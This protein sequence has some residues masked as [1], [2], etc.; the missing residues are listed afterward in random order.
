[1]D[2][3][4]ALAEA[5]HGALYAPSGALLQELP[6]LLRAD[7]SLKDPGSVHSRL[8]SERRTSLYSQLI[9]VLVALVVLVPADDEQKP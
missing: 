5:H 4:L 9:Q 7:P 3:L 1:M 6:S 8:V 2:R